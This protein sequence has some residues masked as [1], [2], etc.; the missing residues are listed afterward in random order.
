[1][2]DIKRA[3]RYCSDSLS[4]IENYEIAMASND[5]WHCHHRKETDEGLEKSELIK[6]NQY[7]NRPAHELIFLS[8]HD[9]L[10]LHTSGK[11]NPRYG[12]PMSEEARMKASKTKSNGMFK[13]GNNPASKAVKCIETGEVFECMNY[14]KKEYHIGNCWSIVKSCNTGKP[15]RGRGLTFTWV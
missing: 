14:A 5:T 7:Y 8:Q 13:G 4:S 3:K 10:S 12:K 11:G 6:T 15:I 1:M 2:I 9:H